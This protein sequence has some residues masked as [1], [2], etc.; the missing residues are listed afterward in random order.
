MRV[1]VQAENLAIFKDN[2]GARSFSAPD[3]E[4]PSSALP[5]PFNL[6]VGLNITL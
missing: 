2:K 6:T 3:P 4:N 5:R 1:Y